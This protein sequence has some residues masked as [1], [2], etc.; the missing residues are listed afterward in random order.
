MPAEA[1]DQGVLE[2]TR[3]R[4]AMQYARANR[5]IHALLRDR[6][7]VQVRQPDGTA[8]P[9]RLT[10]VDWEDPDNNDF[11]LVSQLW[12]HSDLYHRRTDLIGFVNGIPL[13]F[14]ELKASH[15]NLKHAYDDN[16]RDYRDAIP[17]LFVPNGF[18]VLSNGSDT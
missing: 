7:E 14:V 5:E 1:I 16:L 9:E 2:I 11:L 6:V 18:I 3:N 10:V 12:V 8:L 17:S 15:K 13:L 4:G